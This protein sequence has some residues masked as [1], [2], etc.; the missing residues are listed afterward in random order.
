MKPKV[1]VFGH[2]HSARGQE[3]IYWDNCQKTYESFMAREMRGPFRDVFPHAGWMDAV[4]ILVYG[5]LGVIWQWV[6]QGG[7]APGGVLINA[8]C[9]D[10][11]K[12]RLNKKKPLTVTL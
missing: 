3:S 4:K 2:V 5:G 9:Q 6:M 12:G 7:R 11:T 10:G 1:H 8:G